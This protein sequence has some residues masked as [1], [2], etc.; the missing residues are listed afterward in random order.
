MID[1]NESVGLPP[2]TSLLYVSVY[3]GLPVTGFAI[4]GDPAGLEVA[5]EGEYFAS[6]AAIELGSG[7]T[8]TVTVFVEGSIP[9]DVPYSVTLFGPRVVGAVPMSVT[10]DGVPLGDSPW[11]RAG[12]TRLP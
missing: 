8:L 3:T 6:S 10:V 2:G 7:E 11:D 4:D 9:D 5:T 12:T 1:T